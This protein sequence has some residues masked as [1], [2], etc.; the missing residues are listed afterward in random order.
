MNKFM[1]LFMGIAWMLSS[2]CFANQFEDWKDAT[3]F[4]SVIGNDGFQWSGSGFI[5]G[6]KQGHIVTAG[7]VVSDAN[8]I[9]IIFDDN[10]FTIAK[11]WKEYPEHDMGYILVDP[12]SCIS[13]GVDLGLAELGDEVCI[14]GSPFG[15]DFINSLSFGRITGHRFNSF[16][17]LDVW[18]T[19]AA[20]NPGNSG[21][22]IFNMN[23][24]VIG[25]A[26]MIYSNT[27]SFCGIGISVPSE[28]ILMD[29]ID[30]DK[31]Y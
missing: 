2:F 4:I 6:S 24:E 28:Y 7:H 9:Y 17:S 22:P 30:F 26:S 10:S 29:Y 27:G 5:Y 23:G 3:V 11:S 1:C 8:S 13:T 15:Y 16:L 19:D 31:E 21:G 18:Q 12:N 14:I 25:I 20:I